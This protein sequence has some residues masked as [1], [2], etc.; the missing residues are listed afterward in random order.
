MVPGQFRENVGEIPFQPMAGH[1]GVPAIPA[2]FKSTNMKFPV[3]ASP[4]IK[5]RPYLKNNQS[6]KGWQS[7]SSSRVPA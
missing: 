2:T 4:G 7:G 5:V 3:Q 6:K 1:N